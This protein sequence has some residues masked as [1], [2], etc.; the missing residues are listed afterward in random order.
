MT[1]KKFEILI[2]LFLILLPS[3][4]LA[5]SYAEKRIF[6]VESDYDFLE[7]EKILTTNL[8]ISDKA[9]FYV[10]DEFFGNLSQS[11]KQNFYENLK[12]IS[13]EF[14][15]KIYP[16]LVSIFGREPKYG[17]NGDPKITILFHRMKE[18]IGGYFRIDDNFE[19]AIAPLSNER[20]MIYLNVSFLD[21]EI[22]KSNLAHEFTHLIIFNQKTK[23]IEEER[24][25]QEMVADIA[26]TLL[27]YAENLE[28]RIETF[29]KYPQDPILE[30]K[31]SVKDYGILSIFGHYLLD[32]FG[33]DLFLNLL[34]TKETGVFALEKIT[35]KDF[36]EIF[37]NFLIAT[38]LNDCSFGNQYCFKT[39]L[40]KKLRVLPE[41]HFLPITGDS[42]LTVFREIKDFSGDWQKI[43]GGKGNL[44][45]EF[46]G[47]DE[48]DFKI[49][50]ILCNKDQICTLNF[51]KTDQ[52]QNATFSVSD[53]DKNYL[54][55]TLITFSKKEEKFTEKQA[56]SYN[57]SLRISFKQ[58]LERPI[59]PS[60]SS[61]SSTTSPPT[62]PFTFSCLKF[63]RNLKYGMRGRDV[64]CLQEILKKEGK[65]IYP[66]GLITGYFGPLTLKAV[67]KF[68]EKYWQEILAPWGLEK[69]TG[70]VGKTTRAKLN[71]ILGVTS[72]IIS[73]SP[74][75][76]VFFNR[77]LKFGSFGKDVKCLQYL[78]NQDPETKVADFGPGSPGNETNFFGP[79]TFKAVI[80]F[81][82][83][84]AKDILVPL[85]LKKGTGFVGPLTLAK[86][87]QLLARVK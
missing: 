40:L 38:Y 49:S 82:E 46:D 74:C 30:W 72:P 65:E 8:A 36:S 67:I 47:E 59:S 7:R 50:Y 23:E 77:N 6:F 53:F 15:L 9:Y 5:D 14:N 34:K 69:G 79:L 3:F 24:W 4:C 45:L 33:K 86:L 21:E 63:E 80:K 16:K 83:K 18:E 22:I 68:Q 73:I 42:I 28:K 48:G 27:G 11:E 31:D 29:K 52:N 62:S 71:A 43:Y 37:Q 76:G 17:V 26:P 60:T 61:L 54:S 2:I 56:K 19:R 51:L 78:F 87:N 44:T 12:K 20:K 10:E 57:F 41:F 84:Y 85:G 81:Q 39:K 55:L 1:P 35:G 66:Q 32:Y 25:I 64:K 58:P 70:F 75:E 13:K